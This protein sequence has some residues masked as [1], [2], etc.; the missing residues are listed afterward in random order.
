MFTSKEAAVIPSSSLSKQKFWV[1]IL[2]ER[3][4]LGAANAEQNPFLPTRSFP[5]WQ[6]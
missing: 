5:G 3:M 4:Y 6:R 2:A 1:C